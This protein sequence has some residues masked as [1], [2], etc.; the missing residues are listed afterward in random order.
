VSYPR[1]STEQRRKLA[2][3]AR[4]KSAARNAALRLGVMGGAGPG[5]GAAVVPTAYDYEISAEDRAVIERVIREANDPDTV[6]A[7]A[8]L[9]F[10]SSA[11]FRA[12]PHLPA[13]LALPAYAGGLILDFMGKRIYQPFTLPSEGLSCDD[14]YVSSALTGLSVSAPFMSDGYMVVETTVSAAFHL[15]KWTCSSVQFHAESGTYYKIYNSTSPIYEP[16]AID[17]ATYPQTDTAVS[18]PPIQWYALASGPFDTACQ[19]PSNREPA[20]F[21]LNKEPFWSGTKTQRGLLRHGSGVC[22][23]ARQYCNTW[24]TGSMVI[25]PE[26]SASMLP[27]LGP[28]SFAEGPSQPGDPAD[29]IIEKPNIEELLRI[30]CEEYG[31]CPEDPCE[32]TGPGGEPGGYDPP[33]WDPPGGGGPGGGGPGGGYDPYDPGEPGGYEDPGP[34]DGHGTFDPGRETCITFRDAPVGFNDP[35]RPGG[36]ARR[37]QPGQ[38]ATIRSGGTDRAADVV[39]RA[40]T[41]TECW[42][43][44]VSVGWRGRTNDPIE[45]LYP[46]YDSVKRKDVTDQAWNCLILLGWTTREAGTDVS[47]VSERSLYRPGAPDVYTGK[48]KRIRRLEG[49]GV[50]ICFHSPINDKPVQEKICFRGK[51]TDIIGD[52]LSRMGVED[53]IIDSECNEVVFPRVCFPAGTPL[54]HILNHFLDLCGFCVF[55]QFDGRVIVGF[56]EPLNV[57]WHYHEDVD[58]IGFDLEHDNEDIPAIVEVFRPDKVNR[59]GRIEKEGYSYPYPVQSPVAASEDVL[60]IEVP[61]GTTNA[62]VRAIAH[63]KARGFVRKAMPLVGFGVPINSKMGLR[64]QIHIHRPSLGF[65]G[66]YMIT[67]LARDYSDEAFLNLGLGRWLRG[68][69]G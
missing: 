9:E 40:D 62:Q 39:E 55:P 34:G 48:I 26:Q 61:L 69:G 28:P 17:G 57:H 11:L 19:H 60:R 27:P 23:T 51:V 30:L 58:L 10:W 67:R 64:H 49:G 63:S 50:R 52:V 37:Y 31:Y 14:G 43:A 29:I 59:A 25:C 16:R 6:K 41:T 38:R 12:A 36:I 66:V 3:S 45:R 20:P 33:G 8:A 56:C 44:L 47:V 15:Y 46:P 18:G 22:Y 2:N 1:L 13:M 65:T 5:Q 32:P 7:E 53:Y 35:T 4:A 68:D 42:D 54:R 21:E 24:E